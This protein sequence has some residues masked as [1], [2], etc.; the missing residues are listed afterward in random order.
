M[1]LIRT[2]HRLALRGERLWDRAFPTRAE[3]PVLEPYRGYATPDALILRGRVLSH[4]RRGDPQ[5]G[6]SRWRNFRQMLRLFFT[7]E[8]EDVPVTAPGGQTARSD[9]EGYVRL[10]LPRPPDRTGWTEI[11]ARIAG[12]D[13]GRFPVLVPGPEAR[14][15]IISD[16]DDTM[17]HT[18]AHRLW[19]NLWTTFT[20]S[21]LTR[22]VF[23]DSVEVMR[24]LSEE[25][26]N[27]VFYV[28]SS[29][30]NLHAFLESIFDRAGL[31]RGPFFL[32]D[33]GIAED[34]FITRG[35]GHHK[36]TAIDVIL[37]ANPGLSFVLL[38]DTGQKDA[39][40]YR[41]AARRHPGRIRGV[42]LREPG[43]GPDAATTRALDD[44]AAM[45]ID[46]ASG[47]DFDAI[48]RRLAR[49]S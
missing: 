6:Q 14:F 24:L 26:R 49:D 42:Y 19:L 43:R 4:L 7:S 22:K 36:G 12:G 38:G 32:R 48:T 2:L 15:G 20:G 45:G 37:A 21:P 39:I 31:P 33:L 34:Q 40:V 16:V 27:P 47:A 5:E 25:A 13:A 29:P 10:E 28:S 9:E 44:I 1:P 11:E 35:H 30:W 46:C 8:V 23:P 18:G 3:A 17:M 41:D